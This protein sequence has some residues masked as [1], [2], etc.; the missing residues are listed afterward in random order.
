MVA[1]QLQQQ[2]ETLHIHE[3][4]HPVG[5]ETRNAEQVG[6][7]AEPRRFEEHAVRIEI[8]PDT[9]HRCRHLAPQRAADAPG[10]QVHDLQPAVAEIEP[11][12]GLASR[13]VLH[14][15]D[16]AVG[17][18]LTHDAADERCLPAAQ[19]TAYNQI[20]RH[21]S[22]FLSVSATAAR[23]CSASASLNGR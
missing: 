2:V 19:E 9:L 8:G 5:F 11:V 6:Q 17:K 21:A 16:P 14:D 10:T 12:Y 1:V 7:V 20:Q 23:S 22:L 4:H 18:R 15:D 3:H 13:L